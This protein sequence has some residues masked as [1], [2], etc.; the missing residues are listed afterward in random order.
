MRFAAASRG[1]A[2]DRP[3]SGA[4]VH[5]SRILSPLP[6]GA[7]VA[8]RRYLPRM[9]LIRSPIGTR[10]LPSQPKALECGASAP[11]G[12]AAQGPCH[13]AAKHRP[14][15]CDAP[16]LPRLCSPGGARCQCGDASPHSK[17]PCI[18]AL[19]PATPL[20]DCAGTSCRCNF[21]ACCPA[22]PSGYRQVTSA[23]TLAHRVVIAP[24]RLR[25]ILQT[26]HD[27]YN[28]MRLLLTTTKAGAKLAC[29]M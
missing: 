10:M 29:R 13:K 15:E 28:R 6:V 9:A 12:V 23:R 11:L 18:A 1:N 16:A 20:A 27:K 26:W 4:S 24:K 8:A 3:S 2:R 22:T 7:V 14:M 5:P 17:L 25:R 21:L 19:S